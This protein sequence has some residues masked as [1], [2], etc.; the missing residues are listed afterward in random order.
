MFLPFA[1]DAAPLLVDGE[2][3]EPQLSSSGDV[4]IAHHHPA[5]SEETDYP[6]SPPLSSSVLRPQPQSPIGWTPVVA[7]VVWR[8]MLRI[9]GNIDCIKKPAIHAEAMLCLQG[10]WKSLTD[11][12]THVTVM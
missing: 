7:A 8:R 12:S 5:D 2:L 10:I 4:Q 1:G 9:L 11:V 6:S 3:E